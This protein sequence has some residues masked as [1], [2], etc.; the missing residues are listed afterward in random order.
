[1]PSTPPLSVCVPTRD[2]ADYLPGTLD[3]ILAQDVDGLEIVVCDDGSKDT[4][5]SILDGYADRR[6]RVVRHG[7]ARGV[8][9]AR[10]SCLS[11]ARGELIAWLDSDD[12]YEPGALTRLREALESDPAIGMV[13]ASH[14]VIDARGRRLPDWP[15]PFDT[16]RVEEAGRAFS[17][18]LLENYVAAPTVLCRRRALERA[19]PYDER[20]VRGEDW[21]MWLRVALQDRVAY[22]ADRLARYRYHPGSLSGGARSSFTGVR[23]DARVIA[24]LFAMRTPRIPARRRQFRR[25]TLA[26]AA[27]ALEAVGEAY[28]RGHRGESL[29][30]ARFAIDRAAVLEANGF[31]VLERAIRKEDD[32]GVHVAVRDFLRRIADALDGSRF[33]RR[34]RD[35]IEVD[36]AWQQTLRELATV[37][38]D[39]VPAE[40]ELVV[41]DKWDPTLRHLSGRR[42][43]TFPDRRLLP[44]GYPPDSLVATRHLE[45]I[46][47]DGARWLVFTPATLWW[48]EHYVDFTAHLERH[49]RRAWEDPRCVIYDLG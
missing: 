21:H 46:R 15:A 39:V 14:T 2:R 26:L 24:R 42:G 25:A 23:D 10:N 48:L 11:A 38:R 19:G 29:R 44:D 9:A 35:R 33:A 34:L 27:R 49:Y 4:T 18:L 12:V 20:L 30:A 41:A 28:T 36:P 47:N 22:V 40:A 5:R 16:D 6:I 45:R 13:H 32:Y 1:M 31:E 43:R 3:S 37:V 17:E 8:A 7:R